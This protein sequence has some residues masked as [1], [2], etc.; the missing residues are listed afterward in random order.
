MPDAR[1]PGFWAHLISYAS[2][3]VRDAN[4]TGDEKRKR[5]ARLYI[6]ISRNDYA[7]PR[8]P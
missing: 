1:S 7:R 8:L 5:D 6:R 2:A 4:T 3:A